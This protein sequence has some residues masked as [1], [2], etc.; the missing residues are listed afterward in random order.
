MPVPDP[1]PE[2][3]RASVLLRLAE[4]PR[5]ARERALAD[6]RRFRARVRTASQG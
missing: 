5:A 1:D 4:L 3:E 2:P 6:S